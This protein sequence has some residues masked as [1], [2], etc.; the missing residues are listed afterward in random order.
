M[1]VKDAHTSK[2]YAERLTWLHSENEG[3]VMCALLGGADGNPQEV[4]RLV[5]NTNEEAQDN[6]D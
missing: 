6:D 4:C 1:L 2:E 3:M 5:I